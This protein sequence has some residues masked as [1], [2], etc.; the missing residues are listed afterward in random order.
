M[1][2]PCLFTRARPD[3]P[4]TCCRGA[5]PPSPSGSAI[6]IA[7]SGPSSVVVRAAAG[8]AMSPANSPTVISRT[9]A[10]RIWSPLLD[11]ST[12]D[13]RRC[14]CAGALCERFVR[15]VRLA[16]SVGPLRPRSPASLCD[17]A[18]PGS[19]TTQQHRHQIL[20]EYACIYVA[21]STSPR[22]ARTSLH[23]RPDAAPHRPRKIQYSATCR[24]VTVSLCP[25]QPRVR[26]ADAV[27]HVP[28]TLRSTR[29]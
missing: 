16:I 13:P 9:S 24:T 4:S 25:P 28:T 10:R 11:N 22:V 12:R 29:H 23:G 26:S 6:Q 18:T 1:V 15:P 27:H 2:A 19:A 8:S 21:P 5:I 14:H 20:E 7:G 3:D 17:D